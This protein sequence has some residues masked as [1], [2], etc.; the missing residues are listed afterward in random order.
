MIGNVLKKS[1]SYRNHLDVQSG[2]GFQAM[3]L[4]C[5]AM[6]WPK[7]KPTISI[8]QCTRST[9]LPLL[10]GFEITESGAE[11]TF[12]TSENIPPFLFISVIVALFLGLSVSAEEILR[13]KSLLKRERF[14]NVKWRH[15]V[16]AK[17][18]F[19]GAVSLIHATGFVLV[20][21]AILHIP[22]FFLT[23]LVVLFAVSLV[24]K[25]LGPVSYTQLRAHET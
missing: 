3:D 4:T 21:H 25:V 24:G 14:L 2:G 9:A 20:S 19:V 1:Q 11:Y 22:E 5:S 6:S 15:Y 12:R 7:E 17:L 23:H 13:D 16:H 18:T 10:A 8:S